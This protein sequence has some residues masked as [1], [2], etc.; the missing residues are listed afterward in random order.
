MAIGHS[1]WGILRILAAPPGK[2]VPV[3]AGI[4]ISDCYA[5]TC[6]HVVN[7]SLGLDPYAPNK[8]GTDVKIYFDLPK[9][10]TGL[11]ETTQPTAHVVTWYPAREQPQQGQPSDIAVLRLD[12]PCDTP[13][14]LPLLRPNSTLSAGYQGHAYGF[15]ER[16]ASGI[17]ARGQ[18]SGHQHFGW[19][20]IDDVG[21]TAIDSGFSGCPFLDA[22]QEQVIGMV[23]ARHKRF[24]VSYLI[25]IEILFQAWGELANIAHQVDLPPPTQPSTGA[26]ASPSQQQ[27]VNVSVNISMSDASRPAE[28]K[29]PAPPETPETQ[30]HPPT[31][32][33]GPPTLTLKLDLQ[34]DQLSVSALRPRSMPLHTTSFAA[35]R[36]ALGIEDRDALFR[37]LF[38]SPHQL[39]D[40]VAATGVSPLGGD[41][42]QQPL[43]LRLLCT[44]AE[45]AML[46]WHCLSD[47]GRRLGKS[48]WIIELVD[49]PDGDTLTI[50]LDNPLV[51]APADPTLQISARS[52]ATDVHAHVRRLLADRR[53]TVQWASNRRELETALDKEPDLIYIFTQVSGDGCLTLGKDAEHRDRYRL[54]EL[55]ERLAHFERKPLLWLHL[56]EV[57]GA[58]LDRAALLRLR[59]LVYLLLVQITTGAN[60]E[61]SLNNTLGW[62]SAMADGKEEPAGV[63][64]RLGDPRGVHLWLG[65]RSMRLCATPD[66][67]AA[68]IDYIRASL[69]RILL[70]RK[71]EKLQL[72]YGVKRARGGSLLLYAVCGDD[73]SCVHDLPEQARQFIEGLDRTIQVETRPIPFALH[74]AATLFDDVARQLKQD[75][76]VSIAL[77]TEK[78]LRRIA[79]VPPER[80]D[81]LVIAL[82]WLLEVA[83]DFTPAQL[84]D[85]I[86]TWK[87]AILEVLNQ[88]EIPNDYH[89]LVG[90]CIQWAEGWPE[91]HNSDAS[92]LQEQIN[93]ALRR[94]NPRAYVRSIEM[95]RP[96]DLLRPPDLIE[97][98]EDQDS[99]LRAK[100][101]VQ[102]LAIDDLVAYILGKT[103]GKFQ[104]TVNLIYNEC[105]YHYADFND[106]LKGQGT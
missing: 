24:P 52:H 11:S 79:V 95:E 5:L 30:K 68:F 3:G 21:N 101:G 89:I 84:G 90:A 102:N 54:D 67:D 53:V 74:P 73:Q 7:E 32:P 81:T 25:P 40:L 37:A 69:I 38:E 58:E 12:K 91:A 77:P 19:R 34:G 43:R 63:L 48:G 20:Q 61:R 94:D 98:Y 83:A 97:F 41:P 87:Q 27:P 26:V 6:A 50:A 15:P 103:G 104:E 72:F 71:I 106:F 2:P 99:K 65:A 85:W 42:T 8:P 36:R 13:H 49:E 17:W 70:G 82:S 47:H 31:A 86:A 57:R 93:L 35:L 100:L 10:T 23:V 92:K 66:T 46:P 60:L 4:L 64:S 29:A 76:N 75:L 105:K 22:A 14:I 45:V 55:R 1:E 62:M 28:T 56:I 88:D 96:L 39:A 51:V 78:A 16:G 9:S 59:P 33:A 18:L 80:E 44:S